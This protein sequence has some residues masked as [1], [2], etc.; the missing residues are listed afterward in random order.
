MK[1]I[2][3]APYPGTVIVTR[4]K[5]EYERLHLKLFGEH[6]TV[7]HGVQGRTAFPTR[8]SNGHYLVYA[9]P[10]K[11]LA[12]E[13][14]HVCLEVFSVIAEDPRAGNQEPFCYLMGHLM[15]QALKK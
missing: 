7:H 13:F 9:G 10:V 2:S 3:L 8:K 14:A 6:D 12:H 4:D 5:A 15:G 1:K 11:T